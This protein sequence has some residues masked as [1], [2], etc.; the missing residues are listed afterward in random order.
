MEID[1][2]TLNDLAV[3]NTEEE[4]SIFRYLDFTLTS[5]GKE[6]LKRN[7]LIPLQT[8]ESIAGIQHTLGLIYGKC[9]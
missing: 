3:F 8:I 9:H 5:N 4:F 6:Q 2:T 7:L 1:K